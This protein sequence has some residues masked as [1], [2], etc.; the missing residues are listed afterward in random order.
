MLARL[1]YLFGFLV[2]GSLACSPPSHP[3]GG[4][5]DVAPAAPAAPEWP[6]KTLSSPGTIYWRV[7]GQ[8]GLTCEAWSVQPTAASGDDR[9]R[10][11]AGDG[12]I[13][14]ALDPLRTWSY[15][16]LIDGQRKSVWLFE[17]TLTVARAEGG[18]EAPVEAPVVADAGA[19]PSDGGADAAVELDGA[20]PSAAAPAA[21]VASAARADQLSHPVNL[22]SRRPFKCNREIEPGHWFIEQ[23]ACTTAL[24]TG[25]PGAILA[26]GCP[27][28][29]VH[30]ARRALVQAEGPPD[31]VHWQQQ[32]Q[33]FLELLRDRRGVYALAR[34][35]GGSQACV[36]LG[37]K[38]LA[39][40]AGRVWGKL[41]SG[42]Q[43]GFEFGVSTEHRKRWVTGARVPI[44]LIGKRVQKPGA[45]APE[46]SGGILRTSMTLSRDIAEVSTPYWPRRWFFKLDDCQA[47][48]ELG[49]EAGGPDWVPPPP[50]V[51]VV[52][53]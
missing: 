6:G 19:S 50:H 18:D 30:P 1:E 13:S 48:L 29:A 8:N 10:L 46:S 27:S 35:P 25:A 11:R 42:W 40:Q 53:H 24:Q 20:V 12:Q 43:F 9:Q 23:Q 32:A 36:L 5:P 47:A 34:D 22:L 33:R 49:E 2:A 28:V 38:M 26:T 41:P 17:P 16:Y 15:R 39:L 45:A 37:V 51:D 44:N 7:A 21:A 31:S 14:R 4:A 3:V 52:G